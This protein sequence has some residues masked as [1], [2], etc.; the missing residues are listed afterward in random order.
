MKL[1]SFCLI[2]FLALNAGPFASAYGNE[3]DD[4]AELRHL[5]V[6]LWPR[7]YREQ[8]TALLERILAEEF[9]MIDASGRWSTRRDE[10][11]W[12]AQHRPTYDS[13]EFEIVRLE[14]FE[15]GTAVVAGTGTIRDSDEQGAYVANYQST[16][17]LIK[18][19]GIWKAIASHVSG[20]QRSGVH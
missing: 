19:E 5:K 14:I 6:E 15:N 2:A 3:S 10:L 18:R 7:A 20:Y 13:F 9:Q 12:I 11:A 4:A 8:D 1:L 16:N 17:I